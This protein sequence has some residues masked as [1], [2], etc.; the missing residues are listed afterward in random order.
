MCQTSSSLF[1]YTSTKRLLNVIEATLKKYQIEITTH[2]L[3]TGNVLIHT[4][5]L[6]IVNNDCS[7][8]SYY[9]YIWQRNKGVNF[10]SLFQGMPI[11]LQA[12]ISLSLYKKIIDQVGHRQNQYTPMIFQLQ[13]A[14][15]TVCTP[16]YQTQPSPVFIGAVVPEH[17][18][19]FHKTA[20][21]LHK[22]CP[23]S[24]QGVYCEK[25]RHW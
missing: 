7:C 13:P 5:M 19:W 22:T 17:R 2:K 10:G 24:Q 1:S 25:G 11:S 20:S 3:H 6:L 16:L 9:E 15:C 12:D 18:D 8:F 14:V 21:P 23:V 4:A